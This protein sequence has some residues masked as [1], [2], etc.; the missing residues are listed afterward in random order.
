MATAQAG[1]S[2][3]DKLPQ[4]PLI[5]KK[6]TIDIDLCETTPFLFHGKLYRLEWF[7]SGGYLRI[8]DHDAQTEVSRFGAHHRFPCAYAEGDTVYVIATTEDK[9]W[10][11]TSLT[12]YTSKDLQHWDEVEAF[13]DASFKICNTSLCK[14]GDRYLMSIELAVG[15][16][17]GR[18]LES[19]DLIHWTLMPTECRVTPARPT[20]CDGTMVGFT[21]S[22]QSGD[23]PPATCC[24]WNAR[25][26]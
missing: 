12:L 8:M 6:G 13:H 7:R 18:F 9:G 19:T 26:I 2:V 4:R 17:A 10:C 15:G 1:S 20:C 5:S 23:T 24:C 11:G 16:F 25:A 21:C 22:R 3:S 14:A